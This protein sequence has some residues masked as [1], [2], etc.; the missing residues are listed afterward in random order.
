M[1][2]PKVTGFS[3]FAAMTKSFVVACGSWGMGVC[4]NSG[5][6]GDVQR[7]RCVGVGDVI[8]I[9]AGQ[10]SASDYF[11]SKPVYE[12]RGCMGCDSDVNGSELSS[13]RQ[14]RRGP[15]QRAR[16]QGQVQETQETQTVAGRPAAGT[17]GACARNNKECFRSP[18]HRTGAIGT[19]GARDGQKERPSI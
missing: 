16:A 5:Y 3:S 6:T 4:V 19:N 15:V 11:K 2:T 7:R 13:K 18:G 9:E 14:G 8:A 17:A 1:V 12:V 10:A